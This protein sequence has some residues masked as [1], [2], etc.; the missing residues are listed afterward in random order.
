MRLAVVMARET[1]VGVVGVR[2]SNFFGAGSY[3]VNMAAEAGMVSFAASNSFPKVAAHGGTLPVLGTN[4]LAFGAPRRDGCHF[5]LDMA[6]SAVAGSTLRQKQTSGE[7]SDVSLT[8]A[9]ALLPF[10]G[11][12][13]FGLAMMVEIVAGVMT[14][15]GVGAGVASMYRDLEKP[16]NNG[17]F[18]L[19]INAGRWL[20]LEDFEE[21][22]EALALAVKA[23]GPGVALPGEARFRQRK[24][25]LELS[26]RT[27]SGLNRLAH[28]A[29]LQ[30]PHTSGKSQ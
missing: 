22:I 1:G 18:M 10:G 26:D 27:L 21:R 30:F 17:H 13:G 2:N 19:A 8:A 4:P 14:G 25:G 16:G 5:L 11:A 6:T 24:Q 29:G 3:Y 7:T 15:A 23:S 20:A 12:K 9:G 28:E